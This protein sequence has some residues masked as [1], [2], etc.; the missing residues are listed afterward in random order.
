MGFLHTDDGALVV[1]QPAVAATWFPVNDHP[2]DKASYSFRVTVPRG[3]EVVANGELKARRHHGSRSTW[4][5]VAREPMAPYLATVDIGEWRLRHYK[6]GRL[7][8][9]DA[10][11]PDLFDPW[12]SP[13]TGDRFAYSGRGDLGY[14]RLARTI[15]IPAGGARLTFWVNRHLEQDWEYFTVEAHTVG[16]DD[17]TTLPD[18]NG[19]TTAETGFACTVLLGLHPFLGRYQTAGNDD[20]CAPTGTTGEWNAAT[21]VSDGYERWT[22]D[23]GAYAGADVEVAL[24][25]VNDDIIPFLGVWI[26][27]V[28]VSTGS[29]TTSFEDD[30]S[31]LDGWVVPGAPDGSTAN[32]TD[33]SAVTVADSA[34]SL[35]RVVR[36][37]FNRQDNVLR[38]L[39]S[40]FGRYPFSSGGGIVDDLEGLGFALETQTRPV[41]SKDFFVVDSGIGVVVHELAHQWYGDSVSVRKWRHIWLNEGFA[42]YAEW[43]WSEDQGEFTAQ[44]AFDFYLSAIPADDPFWE[45]VIGDPGPESVLAQPIYI[46]GAMTLQALRTTVGDRDFFRILRAWPTRNRN[47]W[48]T[49]REF[50]RLGERISGEQLDDL[51]EE[52][53]FTPAIPDAPTAVTPPA[54]QMQELGGLLRRSPVHGH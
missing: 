35:G 46:R 38:F 37:A 33:W 44:E 25:S 23:L 11:D 28:R 10:I 15:S 7:D 49:T 5:W 34:P 1:G 47:G 18:E 32:V 29:G 31:P 26:D 2:S 16:Q 39:S 52:W 45:L 42:T 13:R 14:K 21:G 24:T 9:W 53:L 3:L 20:S 6:V 19:H 48:G 36:R 40:R 8:M 12:V 4:R 17:W 30:A 51:F 54:R 22:V 43:L 50:L 27:D 41:Y